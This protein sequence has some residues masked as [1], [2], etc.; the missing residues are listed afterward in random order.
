MTMF[1]KEYTRFTERSL[2]DGEESGVYW[3]CSSRDFGRFPMTCL[4]FSLSS[5]EMDDLR[6]SVVVVQPEFCSGTRSGIKSNLLE[7][8]RRV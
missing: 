1:Q 8:D 7:I 5:F 3:W 6:I 2:G 4:G